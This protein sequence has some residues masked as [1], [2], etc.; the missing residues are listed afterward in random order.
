MHAVPTNLT[1]LTVNHCSPARSASSKQRQRQPCEVVH[2]LDVKDNIVVAA[3]RIH[4]GNSGIG[5]RESR[6]GEGGRGRQQT[7]SMTARISESTVT[8]SLGKNE[9]LVTIRTAV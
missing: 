5:E 9:V 4:V 2:L 7:R 3:T 6:E 1:E 8:K